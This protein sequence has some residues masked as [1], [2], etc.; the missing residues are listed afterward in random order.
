LLL[1]DKGESV[2]REGLGE[3]TALMRELHIY[4]EMEKIHAQ[5]EKKAQHK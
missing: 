1:A 2:A 3:G 4:G 5:S